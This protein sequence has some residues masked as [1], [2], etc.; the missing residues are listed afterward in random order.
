MVWIHYSTRSQYEILLHTTPYYD[1]ENCTRVL[2]CENTDA[3]SSLWDIQYS[4]ALDM[5]EQRIH[6][7]MQHLGHKLPNLDDIF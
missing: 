6:T 4:G 2:L 5:F 1:T 3:D 7:F